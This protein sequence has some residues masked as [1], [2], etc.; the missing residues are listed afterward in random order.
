MDLESMLQRGMQAA[1][2]LIKHV[3]KQVGKKLLKQVVLKILAVAGPWILGILLIVILCSAFLSIFLDKPNETRVATG[4]P[5]IFALD[6]GDTEWDLE[7]DKKLIEQYKKLSENGLGSAADM[8]FGSKEAGPFSLSQFEQA[9][10]Y[11]VSWALIAGADRLIGDPYTGDGIHRNPDPEKTYK[12]LGPRFSWKTTTTEVTECKAVTPPVVEGEEGEIVDTTVTAPKIKCSTKNYESKLLSKVDK[13]NEVVT[14]TYKSQTQT[15]GTAPDTTTVTREVISQIITTPRSSDRLTTYVVDNGLSKDDTDLVIEIAKAYDPNFSEFLFP[16]GAAQLGGSGY[17]SAQ[18]PAE[19]LPI[20]EAAQAKYGVPWYYLAAIHRVETVFST[21]PTMVSSAGAIGHTQFMPATW[22]GWTYNVGNGLVSTDLDITNL[23]VIRSGGGYGVDADGDGKADPW[24]IWDAIFSTANYLNKNGMNS[25][26]RK[27]IFQYNH[28]D[29]YV[30]DVLMFADLF[31]K[32]APLW[33]S[34]TLPVDSGLYT[35]SSPFA[36]RTDPFTGESKNHKGIDL[37]AVAGTPVKAPLDG[38]IAYVGK[39]TG[40]GNLVII[41]H[42]NGFSTAY[43]HLLDNSVLVKPK[44]KVKAGEQV[45]GVGSTGRST[46]N[47]LHFEIR[48]NGV[49]VDPTEYMRF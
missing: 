2:H 47:H 19:F 29:W 14:L 31:S 20:Y 15:T 3:L 12:A 39:Q 41:D 34:A 44:Q 17:V 4:S 45:A 40:Y 21:E 23:E 9:K 49:Q 8:S 42:G 28:A 25:D 1:K 38:V 10:S 16:P 30:D 27:A 48:V 11:N 35:I 6:D 32:P 36:V 18:V 43:G 46:G 7:K 37:A 22:V 33:A 13:F 24:N 26:P 5:S